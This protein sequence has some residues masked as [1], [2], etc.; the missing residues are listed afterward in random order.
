MKTL[1]NGIAAAVR[2]V[3]WIVVIVV[4]L[5]SMVLGALAQNFPMEED[6]NESF[7]PDAPELLAVERNSDL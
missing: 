4:V 5:I 6:S 7:A 3:P 2:R 1:V